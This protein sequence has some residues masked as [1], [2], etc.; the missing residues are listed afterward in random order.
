MAKQ[1]P[2]APAELRPVIRALAIANGQIAKWHS[3]SYHEPMPESVLES[4]ISI[5]TS[6]DKFLKRYRGQVT[7]ADPLGD[8]F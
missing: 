7:E 4:L 2:L 3:S 1:P 8:L 5:N 6:S